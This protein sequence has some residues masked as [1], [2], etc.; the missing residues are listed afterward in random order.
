[1]LNLVI[2]HI[3]MEKFGQAVTVSKNQNG[4]LAVV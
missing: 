1:M 3:L 4:A 2:M